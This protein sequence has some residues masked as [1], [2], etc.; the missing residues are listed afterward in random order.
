MVNTLV[1][2]NCGLANPKS[3]IY[4]LTLYYAS[5]LWQNGSDLA[6]LKRQPVF[7]FSRRISRIDNRSFEKS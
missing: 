1:R 7:F 3:F 4:R 5:I 2:G 6:F